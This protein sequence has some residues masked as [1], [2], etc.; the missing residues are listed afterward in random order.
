MFI[1]AEFRLEKL[2]YTRLFI[3]KPIPIPQF[4]NQFS[5]ASVSSTILFWISEID[6]S[7]KCNS[8]S[9][10]WYFWV[11][12]LSLSCCFFS[13]SYCFSKSQ[14]TCELNSDSTSCRFNAA[15]IFKDIY[16][17]LLRVFS[18]PIWWTLDCW[19]WIIWHFFKILKTI[20][21]FLVKYFV[22]LVFI[23]LLLQEKVN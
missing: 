11:I 4:Q 21:Y 16:V 9:V 17:F 13:I 1:V 20:S 8:A 23:L 3:C 18:R 2:I 6:W 5:S 14:F 7:T 22:T 10:F 15:K 19:W 12:S